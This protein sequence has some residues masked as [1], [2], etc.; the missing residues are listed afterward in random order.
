MLIGL[1]TLS[2]NPSPSVSVVLSKPGNSSNVCSTLLESVRDSLYKTLK[3][4][5]ESLK[6]L[7]NTFSDVAG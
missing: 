7:I 6:A 1:I 2:P 3:S 5:E 4:A